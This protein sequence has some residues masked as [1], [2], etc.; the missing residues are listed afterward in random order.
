MGTV[1]RSSETATKTVDVL[2]VGTGFAGLAMAIGLQEA[3]FGDFLLIEKAETVGGT[4]RENTYPGAA[5][6]IPSHLYSLSFA[7]KSDWSRLFPQQPELYAYL[8]EV[9]ERFSL[10][11]MIRF[12][13]RIAEAR[14]DETRR[15]WIVTTTT[16]TIAAR[17]L[18]GGMGPLHWPSIPDLP[19]ISNFAGIC[20]HSSTWRHDYDLAGKRVAVIGTGASAIQFIPPVAAKAARLT[21]FQRT[22]P[23]VLPRNDRPV[24]PGWQRRIARHSWMRKSFRSALF[25]F[26]EIRVLGFLGNRHAQRAGEALGRRNIAK[27][28]KDPALAARVTPDY[29]LGCKRVLLSDEYYPALA[30]PNVELT[31]AGVA[32]IRAH[33]IVDRDGVEHEV[34]AIIHGTGFEVTTAFRHLRIVGTGGVELNR[35]WEQSGMRAYKGIAV[36]HFPNFFL[37][38]GPN[39]GLGHNSVVIMIEAQV[40]YIVDLLRRMRAAGVRAAMPKPEVLARYQADLDRRMARTVWTTGGCK[41]WYLDA[42]GRNTTL[43]PG[44]VIGYK[45][46]TRR[47]DLADYETFGPAPV[48]PD[49]DIA[50]T[51]ACRAA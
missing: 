35:F 28:I 25:W 24:A 11:P 16:G 21:V 41:S 17:V 43:W 2:I 13:T 20:F 3:G 9:A 26:H 44:S 4:W 7:P 36:P 14:W 8:Q 33:S 12:N 10:R 15:L 48:A 30:Q 39:T 46:I 27:A 49:A 22:P 40:R 42:E 37:L 45:R 1:N 29:R 6:D 50:D 5:C 34:D 32:E 38:L 23:W 51:P 19:G 31:T 18:I 47:A